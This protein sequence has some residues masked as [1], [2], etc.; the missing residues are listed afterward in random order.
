[1]KGKA[2]N[3]LSRLPFRAVFHFRPGLMQ[4][5]PGQKSVKPIYRFLGSLYPVLS[6]LIPKH[7]MTMHQVG[8][9]MIRVALEGAPKPVLEVSDMQALAKG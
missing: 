9:A 5:S 1:M 6:R 4:P 7:A 2:E 3:A 8:T